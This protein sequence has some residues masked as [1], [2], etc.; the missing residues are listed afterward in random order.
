VL[1][2]V[3]DKVKKGQVLVELDTAKLERPGA[4]L[5]RCAGG[6][7]GAVAQAVATVKE[8]QG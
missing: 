4:A 6:C 2:D 3:N 5:A 8:A 7:A 1:V